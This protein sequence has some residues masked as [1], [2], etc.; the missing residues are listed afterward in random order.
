MK[1]YVTNIQWEI[2]VDE[3]I[4]ELP[5]NVLVDRALSKNDAINSLPLFFY[6]NVKKADMYLYPVDAE[7]KP[8]TDDKGNHR[9]TISDEVTHISLA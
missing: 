3:I 7:G 5:R 9:V 8:E 6:C 1:I 2:P 4:P